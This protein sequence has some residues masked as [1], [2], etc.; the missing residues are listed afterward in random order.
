MCGADEFPDNPLGVKDAKH[1]PGNYVVI[2]VA[3]DRHIFLCH[4]QKGSITV[5]KGD[6]VKIG[7][8]L[9]KCGNSGNSSAPHIHMHM[10][11]APTFSEGTGQNQIFKS[12]DVEL[13]GKQFTNVDWPL[14]SGLFVSNH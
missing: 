12:I 1:I 2:R 3:A 14:I 6:A 11:D 10:Q 4:F 9:G 13:T 5:K 7:Q 8:V